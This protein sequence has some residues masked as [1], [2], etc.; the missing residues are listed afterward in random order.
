MSSAAWQ[1]ASATGVLEFLP[2]ESVLRLSRTYGPQGHYE[3]QAETVAGLIYG[4]MYRGGAEGIAS[5]LRNVANIIGAFLLS[6][7]LTRGAV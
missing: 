2:H 7:A 5:N 3:R 4:E 6:R 1:T